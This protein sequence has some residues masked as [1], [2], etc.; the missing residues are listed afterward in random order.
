MK[1]TTVCFSLFKMSHNLIFRFILFFVCS[2]LNNINNLQCFIDSDHCPEDSKKESNQYIEV[3]HQLVEIIRHQ[4]KYPLGFEQ[5]QEGILFFEF[6]TLILSLSLSLFLCLAFIC[7]Y[8]TKHRMKIFRYER[9]SLRERRV[10]DVSFG[11]P[12]VLRLSFQNATVIH[13]W[14]MYSIFCCK[15]QFF[16]DHDTNWMTHFIFTLFDCAQIKSKHL[17]V[18]VTKE[19]ILFFNVMIFSKINSSSI[20]FKR[21]ISTSF[22]FLFSTSHW[23]LLL[24]LASYSMLMLWLLL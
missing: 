21:F 12:F 14:I 1:W 13:T 20:F 6:L 10:C 23:Q 11:S 9:I 16:L 4:F 22:C 8:G 3:V 24:V 17:L 5:W 18:T 19:V 15:Y 7:F 2:I